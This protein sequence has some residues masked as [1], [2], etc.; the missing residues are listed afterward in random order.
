MKSSNIHLS[1]IGLTAIALGSAC[2]DEGGLRLA[3]KYVRSETIGA[4]GGGFSVTDRDAPDL[5]GVGIE[6]PPG[7]LADEVMVTVEPADDLALDDE[8]EWVGPAVR[9]GPEG[10]AFSIPAELRLRVDDSLDGFEPTVRVVNGDGAARWVEA[11]EI[12]MNGDGTLSFPVEHFTR[13][14]PGRRA[15]ST[16]TRSGCTTDAD[17]PRGETC[18]QAGVCESNPPGCTS[19][20]DCGLDEECVAGVCAPAPECRVD[21][22]CATGE[23]CRNGLCQTSTSTTSCRTDRDCPAG[24]VCTAGI[25][26]PA[27]RCTDDADCPRGELCIQGACTANPTGQCQGDRDCPADETCAN[28]RCQ[29]VPTCRTSTDCP[30]AQRCVRG[31]CI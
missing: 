18:N 1:I 7:A 10:L 27:P 5:A 14:Q 28:G 17:C 13:F 2:G 23:V 12:T 9:F 3:S 11:G 4:A 20:A 22:D 19:D 8:V 29:A 6:V 24:E 26:A 21:A 30:P 31:L 25:C 15:T 16:S